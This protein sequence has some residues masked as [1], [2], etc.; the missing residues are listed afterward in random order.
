MELSFV[1]IAKR[2][3]VEEPSAAT[4]HLEEIAELGRSPDLLE[5]FFDQIQSLLQATGDADRVLVN[6][7]RF[8]QGSRSPQSWLAFFQREPDALPI[9]IRLLATSQY[10]SELLI[11]D[12]EAF[13]L[14]RMTGGQPVDVELLRDEIAAEVRASP[15]SAAVMRILRNFRHRETLR[16]A[17][18]DFIVGQPVEL[19]TREISNLCD[20]ILAAAVEA[21]QHQLAERYPAPVHDD[22]QKVGFAVIALGKL[23]GRELNYSSDIDLVFVRDSLKLDN[24]HSKPQ[25]TEAAAQEYFNRL[26]QFIIRF[27]GETSPQGIAYRVDMRLRPHGKQ[28]GLVVEFDEGLNY[29]DALGRTWE[30]Q[31]FLKGRVAAGDLPL[32]EDF[33]DQLQPWIYR[34]FL[35]RADIGGIIALKR[36]IERKATEAGES[37]SNIKLGKGGIRDIEYV[38]QFMQLLHGAVAPE[39]RQSNTLA[40]LRALESAACITAD[41]SQILSENYCYLRQLEHYLQIMFD[42]QTHCLPTDPTDLERLVKRMSTSPPSSVAAGAVSAGSQPELVSRFLEELSQR[43]TQN[44]KILDHLLHNAFDWDADVSPEADLILDPEPSEEQIRL[45]LGK[46]RFTDPLAAYRHLQSLATESIAFLSTRRCRHFLSAIAPKLLAAITQTPQP[47]ATLISLVNVTDS[48]GGKSVLWE[49][50]S[51]NPATMQLCLRLCATSPYLTSI[52][53]G[54]PGMLDELLDSLML[55]AL[56]SRDGLAEQLHELCEAADDI[57]P[58]LQSFKNTMHLRVGARNILRKDPVSKI[59][60]SL[61]DIA[62]VCVGQVVQHEYHRLVRQLGIPVRELASHS[63]SPPAQ[64][65][66]PVSAFAAVESTRET[67]ALLREGTFMAAELVVLA[68]GKLGGR[69][70]NYHSD[71]DLIFLFDGEGVTRSLV[72]DRRFKATTNR[73]FFNQLSQRVIHAITRVGA[74]GKLYDVDVRLRPLGRSGEL[75]ITIDDLRN[76]FTLGEAAIWQRQV[77]CKARPIW[78]SEQAQ[79]HALECVKQ[80]LQETAWDAEAAAGVFE[81][82]QQLEQDAHPGNLKRSTGGTMDIEFVVQALQ[83]AGI[84]DNPQLFAPGTLD[85]IERLRQAGSLEPATADALAN[86]YRFLRRVESG[87]RLMNMSARHEIPTSGAKLQRLAYLL[88]APGENLEAAGVCLL[89]QCNAVRQENREIFNHVLGQFI[90]AEESDPQSAP[91]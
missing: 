79:T 41:E 19:V 10:M 62:E 13:E 54:N 38:V 58:I 89:D 71:V 7:L 82:R 64:T 91:D 39:V 59:H 80:I 36:R 45:V 53:T 67:S 4:R 51:S 61:S 33:L 72:P 22:G 49:L 86:N 46:Y 43:T 15:E 40:A 32:G 27:L 35:M 14:L 12:P 76:Y 1:E 37:E 60:A 9:L 42:R 75:A 28:G 5:F 83:L 87:L 50:F 52:L 63:A 48:I 29:Y 77:L 84:R 47:D 11:A 66:G 16:I 30:R 90:P 17:Y 78:G 69:E 73:H 65:E 31:A 18:G 8:L 88:N 70:P 44:R 20:C 3:G 6:L 23:G 24:R 81:H 34:R 57:A 26:G 68:V 74:G 25:A 55:D 2:C 21:A 56:P 85:A